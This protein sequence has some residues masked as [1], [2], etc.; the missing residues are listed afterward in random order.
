[1]Y[2]DWKQE[3][4]GKNICIWGYGIE[5]K[6][7]YRFIRK[8]FPD[9]CITIADGGKGLDV[10]KDTTV[11]TVCISDQDCDFSRFDLI[12]KAPGIVVPQGQNIDTITGEAQLFLKHYRNRTIGIT[13]TKGKSTTT[14]LV[15]A[16]LKEKYPT[17]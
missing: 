17:R 8:L 12:M 3:F 13:G 9:M 4:E 7:T 16:L 15:Y 5:G 6:S 14:S 11:H 10:A 2:E 1:M